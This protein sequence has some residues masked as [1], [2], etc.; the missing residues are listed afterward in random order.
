MSDEGSPHQKHLVVEGVVQGVGFRW[1]VR[2]RARRAGLSGW[3]RNRDDG[4][5]E[6]RVI[7]HPHAIERLLSELA[8]GPKGAVVNAVREMPSETSEA[9]PFPFV[10]D[11]ER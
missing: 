2:E 10:I 1:F 4:S 5:V 9:L 7:G 11:R 3:V 8:I 6:L